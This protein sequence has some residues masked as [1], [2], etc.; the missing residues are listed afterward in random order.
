MAYFEN[1]RT[2]LP[3]DAGRVKLSDLLYEILGL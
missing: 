2:H 3:P 1:R